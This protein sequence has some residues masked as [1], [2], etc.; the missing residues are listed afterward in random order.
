MTV[1]P[2]G[3]AGRVRSAASILE[4]PQSPHPDRPGR[5]RSRPTRA[6]TRSGDGHGHP[7]AD[8]E[9]GDE[10]VADFVH[11]GDDA[12]GQGEADREIFEVGRRRHHDDVGFGAIGDRHRQLRRHR[13]ARHRRTAAADPHDARCG[14]EGR[15][16]LLAG[17]SGRRSAIHAPAGYSAASTA[18]RRVWRRNWSASSCHCDQRLVGR[19]CTA[20]TLYSGQ[21][22]AQSE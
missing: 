6:S 8:V 13:L 19:T 11:A 22:V 2:G 17:G 18:T 20:V 15:P 5:L 7:H 4:M 3:A 14:S 12:F 9:I 16:L 10:E 1:V 21:F